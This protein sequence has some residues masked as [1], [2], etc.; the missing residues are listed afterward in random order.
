M[1]RPTL[2]LGNPLLRQAAAPVDDPL[3]PATQELIADLRDTLRDFR[4]RNGWGRA[5]GA[6]VIGVPQ[7][8]VLVEYDETS[9]VLINPY[10]AGWSTD[11]ES[12]YESCITFPAL[13]GSV[14]RPR[15]VVVVAR[16][17]HGIERRW[18]AEGELARIFQHEIDH[19]DGLVWLDRE[20]DM[21][22]ICT[23]AEYKRRYRN[24]EADGGRQ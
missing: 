23:T 19:L 18:E 5:L 2:E 14:C 12:A 11:E 22:T 20:P 4:A 24:Q 6:P 13:W 8:L 3:S 21:T 1:I 9:I 15:G 10:F 17:E 16:D 7:R